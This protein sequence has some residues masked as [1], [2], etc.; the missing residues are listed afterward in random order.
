MILLTEKR[1]CHNHA[2]SEAKNKTKDMSLNS[3]ELNDTSLIFYTDFSNYNPDHW[4]VET[5]KAT[6]SQV[7]DCLE[8]DADSGCTVW[9]NR[10]L[11]AP[12]TIRYA[13]T[14]MDQGRPNDRVSDN[15]VFWMATDPKSLANFFA[16]KRYG[17]FT[18]YH[19]L[20]LYYVGMGGHDNTKTRFRR[21][22]GN[23]DRPLLEKHDLSDSK[24]LITPNKRIEIVIE[25]NERGT[26]YFRDGKLIY[27]FKDDSPYMDGYFGF[28]TVKNRMRIDELK[29]VKKIKEPAR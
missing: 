14:V 24:Y 19:S 26:R 7:D 2:S 1:L 18:E 22:K 8:I 23:G 9:L 3:T 20:K 5:K 13:V 6:V 21:Y 12:V 16:P 4:V 11:T 10:K 15:N 28:R 17:N 29:I 25:V 27:D